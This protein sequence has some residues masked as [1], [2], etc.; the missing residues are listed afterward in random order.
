M[1][2]KEMFHDVVLGFIWFSSFVVL[3]WLA[4]AAD[5]GIL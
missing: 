5:A 1:T 3:F 4:S 2:K